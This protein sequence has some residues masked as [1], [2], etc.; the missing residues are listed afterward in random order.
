MSNTPTPSHD[1]SSSHFV[2]EGRD[3]RHVRGILSSLGLPMELVLLVLDHARYWTR[4]ATERDAELKIRDWNH[5]LDHSS[6]VVNHSH[7]VF[8]HPNSYG[9]TPKVRRIT[10]DI[11]SH[12]QGWTTEP[13]KGTYKTSSWFEVSIVRGS[14]DTPRHEAKGTFFTDVEGARNHIWGS[15]FVQRPSLALEEQ[16]KHCA[17]MIKV[18]RP[19][20][21]SE[22]EIPGEGTHAWY[23]QGNEV[24]DVPPGLKFY[25]RQYRVRWGCAANSVC[26]GN[27]GAGNGE[28]F[29]D[30]LQDGDW[31]VLWARAKVST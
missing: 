30:G 24:S 6:A 15:H 19:T 11:L 1:L 31:I 23:L 27:D 17:E 25:A 13:T 14:R 4:R 12:D 22:R 29:L 2:P 9:E 28:G 21:N 7:Q 10:F 5:S 8:L 26:E 16:R 20:W 18:T 3:T